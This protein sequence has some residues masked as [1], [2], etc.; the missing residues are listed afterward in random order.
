MSENQTMMQFFEWYLPPYMLW[1]K[2][3]RDAKELAEVGITALWIPPAYKGQA[4]ALDVGYGVYD[5]YD[6]GEFDQKG[7]IP[8]KYG[9]KD[10][11]LE[12]IKTAHKYG[13]RIIADIVLNHKM[14]A[15]GTERV[16]AHKVDSANRN[17]PIG[18][19]HEI[20]AWTKFDFPARESEHSD[21]KW[22]ASHFN[23]V[24]YDAAANETGVFIFE[25]KHWENVDLENG[26]FDYLMGADVDFSNTEV[27]EELTRWGRWFLHTADIDGFRFDAVKHMKFSFYR[28]LLNTLR[29]EEK[30]DLF[31]VG[32]YWH[33][34]VNALINYL[35]QADHRLS[36]FDVPLHYK[37]YQAAT[38]NGDFDMRSLNKDTLTSADPEHSVTF[39]DNH[40]T[41]PNQA[42]Q[43]YIPHWF[44]LHAYAY[45]LLRE[46]GLPCIF[47][48]DYY[49]I[50]QAGS[51]PLKE[52][53]DPLITA[54][55]NCAYGTQRDYFDDPDIVGWTREGDGEHKDSGLAVLLT[56]AKGG[57]KK[58]YV[59]KRFAGKK[60]CDIT[61]SIKEDILI[62]GDG[63]GEFKVL[64]GSCSVYLKKQLDFVS[65]SFSICKLNADI[66][67]KS[68]A[69]NEW[70][71]ISKTDDEVSYVCK[72]DEKPINCIEAQEGYSLLRF[73]EDLDLSLI[74]ILAKLCTILAEAQISV[75]TI[76]TYNTD[77]I[78][79]KEDQQQKAAAAL[80]KHGYVL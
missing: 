61:R 80:R 65:G 32:E 11:L 71:F 77:Y 21:F 73:T 44:K 66:D 25:G 50:P 2:L 64:D 15:D 33:Q 67:M 42:L 12:A 7:T 55:K 23:G 34:D 22:N 38:T 74:G 41:Q 28:D 57:S 37:F 13:I 27:V 53:L 5:L 36:L 39:V 18:E 24:D 47:Y 56:N 68:I 1:R 70:S 20:E 6:L 4:G 26:N 43:S 9:T 69:L 31:S 60:F 3:T 10:E 49:G 35:E 62:D 45:I 40:D 29:K 76:S 46:Q 14:G 54:R 48:G 79:I 52:K 16:K 75:F 78:L 72:S 59:S 51:P 17:N 58:M 63:Y 19:A 30:E 8:T